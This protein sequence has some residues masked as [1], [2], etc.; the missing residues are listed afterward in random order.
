MK[1]SFNTLEAQVGNHIVLE[2]MFIIFWW[3]G[4]NLEFTD[5]KK[6]DEWISSELKT[7]GSN[8]SDKEE[9][10]KTVEKEVT[11]TKEKIEKI[12]EDIRERSENLEERKKEIE[13]TNKVNFALN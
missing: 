2:L 13:E 8:L 1:S 5:Q 11:D 7:Y 4:R 12:T 9:Q 3:T 6:R 10:T